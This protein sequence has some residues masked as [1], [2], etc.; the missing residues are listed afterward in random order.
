MRPVSF[1]CQLSP[2]SKLG[3]SRSPQISRF[4]PAV[5]GPGGPVTASYLVLTTSSPIFGAPVDESRKLVTVSLG[6]C[7]IGFH[8]T[9]L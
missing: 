7:D 2:S 9:C 8:S 5:S 6:F 4:F 1:R 3:F